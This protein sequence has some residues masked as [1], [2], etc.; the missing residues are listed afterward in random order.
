M[1]K[2]ADLTAAWQRARLMRFDAALALVCLALSFSVVEA[3][4]R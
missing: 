3:G 4:Q 2:Y 1:S